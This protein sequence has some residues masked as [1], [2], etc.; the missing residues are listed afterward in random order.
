VPAACKPPGREGAIAKY[1][2]KNFATILTIKVIRKA[3]WNN[4]YQLTLPPIRLI[5]L[6]GELRQFR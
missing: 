2:V 3:L 6:A 1:L 5:L 4:H